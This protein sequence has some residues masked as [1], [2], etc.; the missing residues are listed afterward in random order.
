MRLGILFFFILLYFG[1]AIAEPTSWQHIPDQNDIRILSTLPAVPKTSIYEVVPTKT[2]TAIVWHLAK[3]RF[4]EVSCEDANFLVGGH[5]T[6]EQGK[7]PILIRAVYANGGTGNFSI[8][9]KKRILFIHHGS[10][11][12]P[13][14]IINI[15]LIINL[16]FTPTD[17]FAWASGV[18]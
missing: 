10:M 6:C 14:M 2:D 4:A 1:T 11:G 16:P 17:L 7:R 13:E 18:K 8:H 15:P 12:S 3:E 9:Y 5:F